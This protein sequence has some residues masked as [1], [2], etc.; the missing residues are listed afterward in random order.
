MQNSE[1]LKGEKST[2]SGSCNI[3][4][5]RQKE[6]MVFDDVLLLRCCSLKVLAIYITA[7]MSSLD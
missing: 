1:L 3:V 5:K 7:E 6:L 2:F 4:E